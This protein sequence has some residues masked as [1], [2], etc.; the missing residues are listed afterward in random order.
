[1]YRVGIKF[2]A[3]VGLVYGL[4]SQSEAKKYRGGSHMPPK[5][6]VAVFALLFLVCGSAFADANTINVRVGVPGNSINLFSIL[7]AL[8]RGYYT[9]EKLNLELTG[10]AGV[11]N[12][13][14]K[15]TF[16]SEI[17]KFLINP[18]D[19]MSF[20]RSGSMMPRIESNI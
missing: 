2:M 17:F 9:E 7:T 4:M 3:T 20:P 18:R 1:M 19:T 8:D 11:V 14:V 10:H 5:I 13:R 6:K 16:P 12:S 15:L